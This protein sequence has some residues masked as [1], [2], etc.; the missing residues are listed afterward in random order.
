MPQAQ[1]VDLPKR[2][3]LVI[4]PENR[5][6]SV[7]KDARLVNCYSEKTPEGDYWIF[8]RPG[9]A[10]SSRPYGGAAAGRGMFNWLGNIYSVFEDTL[11]KDGVSLGAV[12]TTNGVYRFS[13][14]KGATPKLQL[15]NG[16]KAYNYDDSNGLV[17]I[18]DVDFPAAFV[19][20]WSYLD[21]TTYVGTAAAA[22]Q[23]SGIN[24]TVD[25]D[26]LNVII[27]QIEPDRGVAL[28]K[29]LV[30]TVM[31]KEWSTEIFYDAGN[32]TGS[33]LGAVQGAKLNYGCK[34]ADSVVSVDGILIWVCVNQSTSVQVMMMEGLKAEIISTDPVERIL[35]A[36]TYT[37]VH[38]YF[39]KQVHR[40]YVLTITASNIT[41]VY[42]LDEKRWHQWTDSSGN[43]FPMV[44]TTYDSSLNLYFQHETDGYI[45]TAS[46]TLYTDNGSI[47]T[48][49]IY[50][51]NFDGGTKRRKQLNMMNFVGDQVA[52][53]T[54][55]V[56]VNDYD[57]DAKKWSN[58]RK[59]DLSVPNAQL[60]NCGT[61][62]RRAHNLRHQAA[63]AFRLRA[64][65]L[66]MDLGTL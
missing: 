63:T 28:A 43:Y 23:G 11:Y 2:L 50:T 19:K 60:G 47:I 4:E 36:A 61:F 18:I 51:P 34:S 14:N 7:A 32:A 31:F 42:D 58:F 55:Q 15:G 20:G 5:D 59:V 8:K 53:S 44:A 39:F 54:L 22:I 40:F 24:N 13:S 29:Q 33:P 48:A 35:G 30:Y 37:T 52:G 49:D 10:T 16:V 65:E 66:Q 21:A 17:E 57:Y 12:N 62:V 26:P 6:S 64:V 1:T 46:P 38:A 56:R 45:Y 41:L 3:P 9:T 25:W 27:A